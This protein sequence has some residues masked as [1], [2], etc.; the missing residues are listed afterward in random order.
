LASR[1]IKRNKIQEVQLKK[2]QYYIA[3]G[4]IAVLVSL[5]ACGH[6]AMMM[7]G[8]GATRPAVAEFGLGPRASAEHRYVATIQPKEALRVRQLQS[9]QVS[10]MDAQGRPVNGAAILIDG[11]M[12]QHGHGLP[13]NPR[14]TKDLG[15]GVYEIEGVRFSMGGW[16]EFKLAITGAAGADTVTF[17]FDL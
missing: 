10:I 2:S 17:N 7:L 5:T 9:M 12:P 8:N 3:A 1:P 4:L 15:G 13:T 11:G 16:W 14:V 6:A